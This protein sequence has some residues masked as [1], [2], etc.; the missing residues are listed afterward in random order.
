MKNILDS[1][2]KG[3]QALLIFL[4]AAIVICVSWQVFSRYILQSPSSVTEELARFL[5][6]WI[7]LFGAAYAYRL[8]SHLGLDILTTRMNKTNKKWADLFSHLTVLFF[9]CY[10]M[11]IGGVSLVLLTMDPSQISASLEIKMG[12]IYSSVPLSGLFIS[13]FA[14]EKIYLTYTDKAL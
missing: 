5:L 4:S 7:G 10:V 12:Y 13:L 9:G 14:I 3:L 2:D 1:L 6:I 11:I 8:G